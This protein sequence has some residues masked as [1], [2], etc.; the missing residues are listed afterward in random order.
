MFLSFYRALEMH[1][2]QLI[3]P[4][5]LKSQVYL[6]LS[7][8]IHTRAQSKFVEFD[9]H[10]TTGYLTLATYPNNNCL[11]NI[12]EYSPSLGPKTNTFKYQAIE[13]ESQTCPGQ[14]P[15]NTHCKLMKGH[16]KDVIFILAILFCAL[17]ALGAYFY[18]F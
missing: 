4:I 17:L 10:S 16:I 14:K 8:Y 15:R 7:K 1:H 9:V 2:L 6:Y 11:Y 5:F 13:A 18:K 3:L 12:Q